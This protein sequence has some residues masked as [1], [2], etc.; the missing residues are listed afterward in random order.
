[1]MD[2]EKMLKWQ[3]EREEADKSWRSKQEWRIVWMAIIFSFPLGSVI[4]VILTLLL[5][6]GG[7]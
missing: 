2:R 3:T 6:K 1:M 7:S 4:G 5:S